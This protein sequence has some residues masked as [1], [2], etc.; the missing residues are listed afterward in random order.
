MEARR[1]TGP[2]LLLDEPGAAIELELGHP[3]ARL[4][5]RALRGASTLGWEHPT[6]R[7]RQHHTG[8]SV[9]LTAPPDQLYTA[10]SLLEW[11]AGA[12]PLGGNQWQLVLTEQTNE[13]N[14]S[15]RDALETEH[16][17]VFADD[18]HGFTV[19]LGRHSQTFPLDQIPDPVPQADGIPFVFVT[20]TNGKTTTTR[21]VSRIAM[22]AGHS[23]G[24]TGS[25]GYGVNQKV[26]ETGDWTGPGAARHIL[27]HAEV[28]FAVL[29]TARGGLLRRGLVM[30]G[31]AAAVVT[32]VSCDHLGEWGVHTVADMA[33]AKLSIAYGIQRGGTLIVN[34][35]SEACL[36]AVAAVLD[37]R[38]DLQVWR[39][40]ARHAEAWSTATHLHV[41]PMVMPLADI[42]ITFDGT[43][44]HN[45]ENAM[46]AALLAR[47]AGISDDAIRT[48]LSQMQPSNEESRGRLNRYVLAN[49]AVALVDFAHN[50]DGVVRVGETTAKWPA[51]RRIVLLGQAGDRTD[52]ELQGLACAVAAQQPDLV[53]L[54]QMA[55]YYCDRPAGET[56]RILKQT[57]LGAGMKPDQ[58]VVV[59][60][61]LA[62]VQWMIDHSE[63]DDLLLLLVQA[64]LDAALDA[65]HTA[66]R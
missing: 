53:V 7:V 4:K 23:V 59:D 50:P 54:K 17:P 62:G 41:P 38:P 55:K 43:A 32:N 44:Q 49:G 21:L 34:T 58:L 66:Q 22:A 33:D 15:L 37:R 60:S 14:P 8:V 48:G 52:A 9:A 1:I 35:H 25:D 11:A 46:C 64:D 56:Q 19:G 6:L 13:V 40:G 47:A 20:G 29:E 45:V 51:Q 28:D 42:P 16:S 27:R 31:A 57:L 36:N 12:E 3:I 5:D 24:W 2:H 18:D 61:E 10:C 26:G 65:V 30:R 63:P 39:F